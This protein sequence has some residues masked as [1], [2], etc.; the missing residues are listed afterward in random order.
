MGK[1]VQADWEE[2]IELCNEAGFDAVEL[3][4][5]CNHGMPDSGMGRAC[6]D[7]AEAV[8][9]ITK[10]VVSKAKMPIFIKISPNSSI[11][12]ELAL[13]VQRGGGIGVTTTNTM[14]S[15]MDP[16]G[17]GI[18]YPNV[19]KKN[20]THYGGAAGPIIRPIALRVASTIA[21]TSGVHLEMM[22]SGGIVSA[23]HA[24]TFLRFGG[25]KVFQI[26]SA[27]QEQDFTIIRDLETGLKAALYMTK[28][29]DLHHKGWK[30]QSP[31][32]LKMQ[33]LRNYKNDFDLWTE[34][35][36]PIKV[37]IEKVPK[38]N[39]LRGEGH[40]Y[41]N[42]ITKMDTSAQK[43]PVIDED[44]CVNCGKCYM[45]CLDS[46]YQAITFDKKSHKPEITPDCT[47]CGLCVAVCPVPGA[48]LF[49][50]RTLPYTPNR[51]NI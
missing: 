33:K 29:T 32:M 19:G 15:L 41:I 45:T 40:K 22:A 16:T 5:S 11:H 6:S 38:L 47:G 4:L 24:M 8:E 7:S 9:N 31:P 43:F 1:Y 26:C 27:V 17:D 23:E 51:G 18:P 21:N 2:L 49:T 14:Y 35:E 37:D 12:E 28:R 42:L 30:G 20:E 44:I 50:D 46:G 13:A 25:T 36:Q 3:N 39:D 10:W 48:I 34:G